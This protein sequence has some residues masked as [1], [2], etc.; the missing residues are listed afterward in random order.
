MPSFFV[1]LAEVIRALDLTVV[2]TR[3]VWAKF[4]K[5]RASGKDRFWSMTMRPVR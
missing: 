5:Q 1:P 2:K 4:A 3:A